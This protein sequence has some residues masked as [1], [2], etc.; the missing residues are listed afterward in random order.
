MLKNKGLLTAR[1]TRLMNARNT[2]SNIEKWR[3]ELMFSQSYFNAGK[4]FHKSLDLFQK[5]KKKPIVVLG[6]FTGIVAEQIKLFHQNTIFS[7]I[8]EKYVKQ[9]KRKKFK[10]VVADM[11]ESPFNP[12]K[13]TGYFLFEPF[14]MYMQNKQEI[15]T[16][17]KD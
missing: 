11:I 10:S 17:I 14:P 9:A 1:K 7:D 16:L 5:D 8:L 2:F 3:T 4:K 15:K 13:I 6:G 12:K